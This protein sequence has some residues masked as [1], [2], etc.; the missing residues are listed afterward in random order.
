V[1]I[2]TDSEIS[3]QAAIIPDAVIAETILSLRL[4]F[5]DWDPQSSKLLPHIEKYEYGGGL[6]FP[7]CVCLSDF[8]FWRDR[9]SELCFEYE[10]PPVSWRQIWTDRR[11]KLQWYTFWLAFTI[12]ILTVIFGMISSV[13]ACLQTI[14]A[15]ETLQLARGAAAQ[16]T[17]TTSSIAMSGERE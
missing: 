12:L 14:Y 8:H 13:T 4:L 16:A 15:Y 6:N 1:T 5:P 2:T 3:S 9:L 10:S 11:N 7:D 17:Q